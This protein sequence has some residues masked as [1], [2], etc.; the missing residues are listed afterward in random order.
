[1]SEPA[2]R[3]FIPCVDDQAEHDATQ[4]GTHPSIFGEIKTSRR[5]GIVQRIAVVSWYLGAA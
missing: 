3:L 1:M 4:R 5:D 2:T